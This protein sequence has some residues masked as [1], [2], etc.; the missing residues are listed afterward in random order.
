MP[1]DLLICS[2]LAGKHGVPAVSLPY[3]LHQ[4]GARN[5]LSSTFKVLLSGLI[6]ID[7][8]QNS[9]RKITKFNTYTY[10]YGDPTYMSKSEMTHAREIWR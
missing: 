5:R 2:S 10:M 4:L 3:S 6:I 1:Q 8:R 7:M 9:K